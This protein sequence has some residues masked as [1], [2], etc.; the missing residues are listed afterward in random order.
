M[1]LQEHLVSVALG[2][3]IWFL[4]I[5]VKYM[6]LQKKKKCAYQATEEK[7]PEIQHMVENNVRRRVLLLPLSYSAILMTQY[8]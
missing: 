7:S 8:F 4:P 6:I 1:G 2:Q 3:A 5:S